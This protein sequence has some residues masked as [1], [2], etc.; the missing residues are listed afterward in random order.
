MSLSG[1][2]SGDLLT[3]RYGKDSKP[4]DEPT[5]EPTEAPSP[6]P[7]DTPEPTS[8]ESGGAIASQ[9]AD[10][11]QEHE[12]SQAPA[13]SPTVD[14]SAGMDAEADIIALKRTETGWIAVV[15]RGGR[16]AVTEI[17]G[18]AIFFLE[19]EQSGLPEGFEPLDGIADKT[20]GALGCAVLRYQ[21]GIAVLLK[22]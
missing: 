8:G 7:T 14:P 6:G 16:V 11:T 18:G 3:A 2:I 20:A 9:E 5:P 1:S 12:S 21:N 15:V 22:P 13:P 17:N 10:I 4:N 19:A